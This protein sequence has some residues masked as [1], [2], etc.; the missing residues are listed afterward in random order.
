MLLV[1]LFGIWVTQIIYYYIHLYT[2]CDFLTIK[3]YCILLLTPHFREKYDIKERTTAQKMKIF[4]KDFFSK[5]D[6]I[7]RKLRIWSHLLKKSLMENFIFCSV[8]ITQLNAKINQKLM[9]SSTNSFLKKEAVLMCAISNC[10][11]DNYSNYRRTRVEV[12][13]TISSIVKPPNSGHP[14]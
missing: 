12:C 8:N 9:N 11:T 13:L 14:K 2:V 3:H 7:R 4:S 10:W 5:W 6:Q 1:L